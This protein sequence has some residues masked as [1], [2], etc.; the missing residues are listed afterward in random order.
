MLIAD[1]SALIEPYHFGSPR[2]QTEPSILNRS[3]PLIEYKRMPDDA[4]QSPYNMMRE[5]FEFVFTHYAKGL[6]N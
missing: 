3:L 6:R 5:H 1:H 4:A 2:E